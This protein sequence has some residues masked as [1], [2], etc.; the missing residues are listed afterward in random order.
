MIVLSGCHITAGKMPVV[1]R[2]LP[3][4][5]KIGKTTPAD[6]LVR[7]G[8]PVIYREYNNRTVM[9]YEYQEVAFPPSEGHDFI[10]GPCLI[11][12]VFED[13]VLKK[14]EVKFV[15]SRWK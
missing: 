10:E 2:E 6:V 7:F 3:P 14:T 15:S 4:F 9:M 5:V 13:D 1:G 12:L 8:E 11:F